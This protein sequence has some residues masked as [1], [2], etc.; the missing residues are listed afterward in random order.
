MAF[1]NDLRMAVH[2]ARGVV[3]FWRAPFEPAAAAEMVRRD[4]AARQAQFADMLRRW[5]YGYPA[6]PYLPLLQAAGISVD[7]A[8]ALVTAHGVEGAL[9]RLYEAGVY[10]TLDEF[11]AK[12]PIQRGR[13]EFETHANTFDHP[14]GRGHIETHSG[15]TRSSGTRLVIDMRDMATELPARAL[16]QEACG[17]NGLPFAMWRPAPPALAGL[18]NSIECLKLGAP[19]VHWFSH[20]RPYATSGKSAYLTWSTHI[21]SALMGRRVPLPRHVSADHPEVVARWLAEER[22]RGR[23]VLLDT[24]ASSAVRVCLA[25]RE[26]GLDI[27]GHVVRTGG[28]PLTPAKVAILRQ[29]G[30]TPWTFYSIT[31]AGKIGMC[32]GDPVAADDQHILGYRVAVI[33][34]PKSVAGWETPVEALY[35]SRLGEHM[36]RIMLNVE[37]GDYGVLERRACG[38]ALGAAGLDWHLHTIRSYEKLTS[39]GMHFAGVDLLDLLEVALPTRFGGGPTDYQLVERERDGQTQTDL[40]IAPSVGP[41]DPEQVI[42]FALDHLRRRATAGRAMTDIWRDSGVL[43]VV[44]EAPHLTRAAKIQPL[45]IE[46]A[47]KR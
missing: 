37:T 20:T 35:V 26:L 7:Q 30:L 25:A 29:A 12:R 17:M 10:V 9:G 44:R 33:Q 31:E 21:L 32:C 6:S 42:A 47:S 40:L 43:R 15:A 39:A 36:P 19:M 24:I 41:L 46:R 28:E 5:V 11:K 13:V 23:Q 27:S 38:C 3:D 18:K 1:L 16:C 34:R 4:M 8:A 22:A 14:A 45:H 2:Y